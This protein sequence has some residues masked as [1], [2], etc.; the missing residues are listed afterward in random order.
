MFLVEFVGEIKR[1]DTRQ[2]DKE[3]EIEKE[4]ETALG[5]RNPKERGVAEN[6]RKPAD[7]PSV[8]MVRSGSFGY[9]H[10]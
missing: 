6:H 8:R 10:L 2:K 1:M 9:T 3:K 4:K 7:G 5:D